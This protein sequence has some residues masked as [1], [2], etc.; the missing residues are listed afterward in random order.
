MEDKNP[1]WEVKRNGMRVAY[2]CEATF[3]GQEE[4]KLLRA[5]WHKIYKDGKI[6][7]EP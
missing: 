5:G 1:F 3:P 2:G 4:R 6:F 7:K